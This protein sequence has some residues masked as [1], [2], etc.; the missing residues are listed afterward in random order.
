[1]T[2]LIGGFKDKKIESRSKVEP[3]TAQYIGKYRQ[4]LDVEAQVYC[5]NI[6]SD[7][8]E[9]NSTAIIINATAHAA[10]VG[11]RI[12]ITS[13]AL[14]GDIAYVQEVATNTITLSQTLSAA[15]ATSVTFDILRPAQPIVDSTGAVVVAA[16]I[17]TAG[18][19]TEAKQDVGNASLAT[20]DTNIASLAAE[21][22]AT[23]TTLAA[24]NTKLVSGTDIGDVTINN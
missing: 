16:T 7:A 22:F 24:I 13:G 10:R 2:G 14:Q 21:D 15:P 3:V 12:K 11:D 9:A 17:S 18:L 1:M 8:V 4:G 19:A 20:I 5:Q 6:G 23:Q